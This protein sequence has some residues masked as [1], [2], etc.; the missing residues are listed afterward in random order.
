MF[1]KIPFLALLAIVIHNILKFIYKFLQLCKL[2]Q[3]CKELLDQLN[4]TYIVIMIKK[5]EFKE[6][7]F[8]VSLIIGTLGILKTIIFI[9]NIIITSKLAIYL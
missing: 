2:V 1:S 9:N 8:F 4:I 5:S 6:L 7:N 3:L